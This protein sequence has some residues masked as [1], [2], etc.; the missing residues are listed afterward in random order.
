[1]NIRLAIAVSAV[2]LLGACATTPIDVKTVERGTNLVTPERAET[3]LARGYYDQ[4]A[5]A[6]T[7]ALD[8]DATDPTARHGLAEAQRLGGRLDTAAQN[9]QQLMEIPEWKLRALEGLAR[10]DFAKGDRAAAMEKFSAVVKEDAWAWKSWLAIA[11]LSD[12]SGDWN[13]ADEAYA[14]ALAATKE[15][16]AVYNNHGVSLLARGHALAAAD[17]FRKAYAADPKMLQAKTNIDL[18]EARAGKQASLDTAGNDARERARTLNNYGYV[19]MLQG[20]D[21][22]ARRYYEAAI[23]EHPSFYALAYNN[24]MATDATDA[25]RENVRQ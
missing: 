7:K 19:A 16:A 22:D 20:R 23:K 12:L 1:M 13:R 18:A 9:Y 24:L 5:A 11:Q 14:M 6:Y 21:T 17:L 8:V 25:K 4:A 10:I 2:A 3:L 15:P